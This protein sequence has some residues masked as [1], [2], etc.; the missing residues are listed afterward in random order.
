[1]ECI[2]SNTPSAYPGHCII[3]IWARHNYAQCRVHRVAPNT[4]QEHSAFRIAFVTT[5]RLAL[6]SLA[7]LGRA[8]RL[9]STAKT[10]N[11]RPSTCSPLLFATAIVAFDQPH[12]NTSARIPTVGTDPILS[13]HASCPDVWG[14]VTILFVLQANCLISRNFPGSAACMRQG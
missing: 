8:L 6:G 11:Q 12:L 3:G 1:M 7:G 9:L 10:S 14:Q 2:P 4:S 13:R 5:N